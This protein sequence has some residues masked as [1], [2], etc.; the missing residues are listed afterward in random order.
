MT[1]SATT[2]SAAL[3]IRASARSP[4]S[5]RSPRA[6]RSTMQPSPSTS[7]SC[8]TRG[9]RRQPSGSPSPSPPSAS[10]RSSPGRRRRPVPPPSAYL[11]GR[12]A[13]ARSGL[14]GHWSQADAAAAVA[15][16]GG[17]SVAG[18]RDAAIL[19]VTSDAMLRVSEVAALD[20]ADVERDSDGSGRVT[21]RRSKSD[22]EARGA[23][24]YIGP[25][26][27]ARIDAWLSAAGHQ[28][29]AMFRSIRRGGHVT[30]DAISAR[31]LGPSSPS[32]PRMPGSR[33]GFPG[34][35]SGSGPLN[36]SA[37]RAFATAPLSPRSLPAHTWTMPASSRGASRGCVSRALPAPAIMDSFVA[38][39]SGSG[40]RQFRNTNGNRAVE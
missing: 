26:T 17:G 28:A 38:A 33:V 29:G 27:V 15:A 23:V 40:T 6:A 16:N 5:I 4:A 34:I 24:L 30:A 35:R 25:A 22:Q 36:R 31:A 39:E 1:T 19:A 3:A 14:R 20:C 18:L 37:P 32:G 7:P 2:T 21:V 9:S 12:G 13:R 11:P 10:A 8:T